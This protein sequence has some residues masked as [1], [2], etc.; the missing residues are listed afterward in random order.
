MHKGACGGPFTRC[1]GSWFRVL[2]RSRNPRPLRRVQ[3]LFFTFL[4]SFTGTSR[5]PPQVRICV[6]VRAEST[7]PHTRLMPASRT[8]TIG[9]YRDLLRA[10]RGFNN[11]NFREYALRRVREDVREGSTIS[12][13]DAL[14]LAYERGRQQLAMLRRQSAISAMFPQERHAM[15]E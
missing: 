2:A 4:L 5:S 9:L 15:E 8:A 6:I 12:G 14:Q 10:A 13:E 3:L 11:Y 1:T 7:T